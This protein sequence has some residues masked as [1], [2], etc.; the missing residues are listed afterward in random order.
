MLRLLKIRGTW[1][2]HYQ[3]L[4]SLSNSLVDRGTRRC[5]RLKNK[6]CTVSNSEGFI[7]FTQHILIVA[8]VQ[9]FERNIHICTF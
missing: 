3:F 8:S 2:R 6:D 7:G 4:P 5:K 1:T 9:S